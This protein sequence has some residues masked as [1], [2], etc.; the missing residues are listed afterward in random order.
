MSAFDDREAR[1]SLAAAHRIA[2]LDALHEGS[3]NHFSLRTSREPSRVFITPDRTHW[4]RVT[5]SRVAQVHLESE[6]IEAGGAVAQ[7]ALDIHLPVL[8]ARPDI[9]CVLHAHP[10]YATALSMLK[11][12]TLPAS[13][14]K[15]AEFCGRIAYDDSFNGFDGAKIARALGS[16][17]V[18][19]MA[20]H[21]VTVVGRTIEQA[22]TDL[23][24]LERAAQAYMLAL[25]TGREL[26]VLDAET[27]AEI[28]AE[29]TTAQYKA[30]H[31]AAMRDW[32]DA[33]QP[34]YAT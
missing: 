29:S 12:P 34:D 17:D 31:F 10:P 27:S 2:V 8:R 23:Y 28:G 5:G 1:I 20:H 30:V 11:D 26:R 13:D 22:Y 15:A 33:F 3:W 4:S 21:G 9:A 25:A 32:L 19:L 7:V 14:Q 24:L 6:Q 16:K 18:L